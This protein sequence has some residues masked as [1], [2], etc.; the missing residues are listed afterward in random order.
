MSVLVLILY[1]CGWHPRTSVFHQEINAQID[2]GFANVDLNLKDGGGKGW[3]LVFQLNL[4]HVPIND[5][6][7]EA[8]G[9]E[10]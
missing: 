7:L 3:E 2:Q 6:A 5:E 1:K 9:V 8:D 4:Y 10:F